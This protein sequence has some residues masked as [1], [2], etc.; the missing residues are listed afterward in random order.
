MKHLSG[1]HGC[2]DEATEEFILPSGAV[3]L[4]NMKMITESYQVAFDC[5]GHFK[6]S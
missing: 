5:T 3:L 1:L 2:Y 4:F 6:V